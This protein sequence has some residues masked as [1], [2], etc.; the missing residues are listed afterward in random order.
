[1]LTK[2]DK[3]YITDLLNKSFKEN[4]EI[5]V[6]EMTGLFNASNSRIDEVNENLSER[7]DKVLSELKDHNDIIDNHERRIEK[8]EEKVFVITTGS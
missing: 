4:N 8:V 1:M 3:K 5:L 2:D 6:K 7:I